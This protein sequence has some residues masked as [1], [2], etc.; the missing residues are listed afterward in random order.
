MRKKIPGGT[1][2]TERLIRALAIGGV[3]AAAGAG[4]LNAQNGGSTPEWMSVDHDGKTVMLE[5]VAG[6]TGANNNWNYNGF[7]SGEKTIVV[8]VGYTVTLVFKNND[9]A[10]VHSAGVGQMETT[11]PPMYTA[12]TPVFDGAVSANPTD[13]VNATKSGATETLEF[14]AETAGEYALICYIPAHALTG[15]WLGFRVSADGEVGVETG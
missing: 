14:V 9:A 12:V 7:A 11:W 15:M 8:P 3:L 6:A 4:A 1:R 10:M 2:M 13:M 5:V